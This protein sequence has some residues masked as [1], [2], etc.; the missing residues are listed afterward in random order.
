MSFEPIKRVLQ[1]SVQQNAP[2]STE[3]QIARVFDA[4]R[5][6]LVALWGPDRAAY[7]APIS[8]REG[9]LKVESTSAAALQQL[10][11]DSQRIKNEMNRLLGARIIIS[12]NT[13]AKGF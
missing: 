1:R 13:R 11:V 4:W 9:T 12:L 6:V 3:L 8:F 7:V 5:T 10:T 2:I